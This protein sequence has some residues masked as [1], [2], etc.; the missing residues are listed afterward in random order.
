MSWKEIIKVDNP[1]G[2]GAFLDYMTKYHGREYAQDMRINTMN[3]AEVFASLQE[4]LNVNEYEMKGAD[5]DT[6]KM[7]KEMNKEIEEIMK[8]HYK[9]YLDMA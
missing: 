6:L 8:K 7:Y 9:S 5:S 2:A 3:P 1:E 4:E